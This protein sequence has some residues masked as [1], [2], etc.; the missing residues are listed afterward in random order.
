MHAQ[1]CPRRCFGS[2]KITL[3][4]A[5]SEDAFLVHIRESCKERKWCRICLCLQFLVV[6][7]HFFSFIMGIIQSKVGNTM[8]P[9]HHNY[10]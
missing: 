2:Q 4:L 9:V 1:A 8:L 7:E 6:F 5:E 3:A 10:D